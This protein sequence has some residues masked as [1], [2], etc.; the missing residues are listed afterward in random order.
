MRAGAQL[1]VGTVCLSLFFALFFL[2]CILYS[3]IFV[4]NLLFGER[5]RGGYE[6]DQARQLSEEVTR[7]RKEVTG[8]SPQLAAEETFYTTGNQYL[9][10]IREHFRD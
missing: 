7:F 6:A 3:L 9:L 1:L 5:G 2:S 10:E 8:R 4:I